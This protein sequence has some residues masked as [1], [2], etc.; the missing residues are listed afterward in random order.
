MVALSR[1]LKVIT[2]LAAEVEA[3]GAKVSEV[4]EELVVLED[5]FGV[6]LMEATPQPQQQHPA[7]RPSAAARAAYERICGGDRQL[8]SRLLADAI[9]R[10]LQP[11]TSPPSA[12][13]RSSGAYL[14]AVGGG[15]SA[16]VTVD[17]GREL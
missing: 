13:S 5:R 16:K 14:G 17:A 9:L 12:P 11:V 4:A 6:R 2:E 15:G 10:W 3:L 7:P 8:R 1:V